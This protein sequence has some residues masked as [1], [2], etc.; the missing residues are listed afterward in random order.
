MT[1]KPYT[2]NFYSVPIY[3][4]LKLYVDLNPLGFAGKLSYLH[5]S[6]LFQLTDS[7][8]FQVI[9]VEYQERTNIQNMQQNP[10]EI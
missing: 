4:S 7:C 1:D 10:S 2:Y 3:K 8:K 9:W 6:I 5:F